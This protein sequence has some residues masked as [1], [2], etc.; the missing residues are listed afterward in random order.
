MVA[1]AK[2]L[3]D[4]IEAARLRIVGVN[5]VS[6]SPHMYLH[7]VLRRAEG[8]VAAEDVGLAKVEV[9]MIKFLVL[10]AHVDVHL[11]VLLG[12]NGGDVVGL[13]SLT[14]QAAAI[15]VAAVVDVE[16]VHLYGLRMEGAVEEVDGGGGGHG[17]AA[18]VIGVDIAEGRA[19]VDV[20]VDV[21]EDG[22]II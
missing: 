18:F 16:A 12:L 6:R 5:G 9:A 17:A 8:V 3:A 4:G 19:A 22:S 14:A 15:D 7:I 21:G 1:A 2:H 13:V 11:A 10:A 20:A